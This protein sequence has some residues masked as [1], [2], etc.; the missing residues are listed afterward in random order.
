MD[1]QS[2]REINRFF[3]DYPVFKFEKGQIIIHPD[4]EPQGV[5][6]LIEG[7]ISEYD[8]TLKGEEVVVNILKP[9]VFFPIS[10]AINQSN[11][12]FFYQARTLV[13]VRLAPAQDVT[14]FLQLN[15]EVTYDLLRN[16]YT[17][18]NGL[19]R[20]LAH[21]LGGNSRSR[22][23]YELIALCHE[24]G[25]LKSSGSYALNLHEED[26]ARMAG[27]SR[28]TVSRELVKLKKMNLVTINHK[29]II[30]NNLPEIE[31]ELGANL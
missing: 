16:V 29:N 13:R 20:Q 19:R 26:F 25:E 5:Y 9:A 12:Q 30:V 8:I 3:E 2:V 11:N 6:Q 15:P 22:V 24:I 18:I 17:N 23:L 28:E 1:I 27:L 7:Q 31:L 4:I 21:V 10:W 14:K